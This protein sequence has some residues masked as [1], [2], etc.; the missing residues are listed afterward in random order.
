MIIWD[1]AQSIFNI[2]LPKYGIAKSGF[3]ILEGPGFPLPT[4]IPR[5][6]LGREIQQILTNRFGPIT[7]P[8]I[9]TYGLKIG[10]KGTRTPTKFLIRGYLIHPIP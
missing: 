7:F 3:L 1:S 10:S 8:W 5:F 2:L 9:S 4:G 6:W